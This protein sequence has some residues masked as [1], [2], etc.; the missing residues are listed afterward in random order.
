MG[1]AVWRS[2][3]LNVHALKGAGR[4]VR[5]LPVRPAGGKTSVMLSVDIVA[6]GVTRPRPFVWRVPKK[7]DV[8]KDIMARSVNQSVLTD[9]TP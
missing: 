4:M 2:V 8:R 1:R 6:M 7:T 5:A 3:L 9:V